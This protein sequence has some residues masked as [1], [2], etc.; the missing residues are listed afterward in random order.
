MH[1]SAPYHASLKQRGGDADR[2]V[3]THRRVD[4]VLLED[5]VTVGRAFQLGWED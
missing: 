4:L 3:P 1:V 2:V 5:D